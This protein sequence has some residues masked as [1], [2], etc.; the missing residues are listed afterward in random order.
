MSHSIRVTTPQNVNIDF[1]LATV[2]ERILAGFLDLIFIIILAS[3]LTYIASQIE[4][5]IFGGTTG[6]LVFIMAAPLFFYTLLL[7]AFWDGQTL[8]KRIMRIKVIA[9]DGARL[10]LGSCTQRWV[11]RIVDVWFSIAGAIPGLLASLFI[12]ISNKGQ[13]IGDTVA[14]T[15]VITTKKR[16]SVRKTAFVRIKKSYEPQYPQ[17]AQLRPQDIVTLK[18]VVRLTTTNRKEMNIDAAAHIQKVLNVT[19]EEPARDFLIRIVKDY[20]YYEQLRADGNLQNSA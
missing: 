16:N 15:T 10:T 9:L 2:G 6:W 4:N 17:A 13:R 1:S 8:G 5:L 7:E 19:K 3:L 18:E 14:N 11:M 20:N 12:I